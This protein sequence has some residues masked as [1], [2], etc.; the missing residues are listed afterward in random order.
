MTPASVAS[1]NA[2]GRCWTERDGQSRI[3]RARISEPCD[4]CSIRALK[5]SRVLDRNKK[6]AEVTLRRL[7]HSSAL[8]LERGAVFAAAAGLPLGSAVAHEAVKLFRVTSPT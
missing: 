6:A 3:E 8:A 7:W 2:S 1:S 4:D 5:E